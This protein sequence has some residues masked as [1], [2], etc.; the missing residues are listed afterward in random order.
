MPCREHRNLLLRRKE[1]VDSPRSGDGVG[2]LEP[3][4]WLTSEGG[5]KMELA[6]VTREPSETDPGT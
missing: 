3:G 2:R 4:K 6:N 5:H 1:N